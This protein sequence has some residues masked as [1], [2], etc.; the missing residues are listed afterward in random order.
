M[1]GISVNYIRYISLCA[2]CQLPKLWKHSR[3]QVN[4]E[5]KSICIK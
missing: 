1:K 2:R 3:Q 4:L 5:A